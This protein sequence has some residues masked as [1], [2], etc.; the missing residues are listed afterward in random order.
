MGWSNFKCLKIFGMHISAAIAMIIIC[1]DSIK[2][3]NRLIEKAEQD[4]SFTGRLSLYAKW[5]R[6]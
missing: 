5:R 1:Q 4:S 6:K 3:Y 2:V